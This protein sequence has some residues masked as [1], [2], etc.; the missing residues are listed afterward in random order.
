MQKKI[1]TIVL[2]LFLVNSFQLKT[3][4]AKQDTTY[5][6]VFVGSSLFVLFNLLP[7]DN[8]PDFAQVN[9]GYRLSR[10]DAVSK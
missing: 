1:L 4:Y 5:K 9:F 2:A 8:A 7:D 3:Q 6:K 10:K